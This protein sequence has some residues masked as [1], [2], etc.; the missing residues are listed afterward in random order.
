MFF[1]LIEFII[2]MFV[3]FLLILFASAVIAIHFN[4]FLSVDTFD[5]NIK[6][7]NSVQRLKHIPNFNLKDESEIIL[8]ETYN[9]FKE[10]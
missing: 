5:F 7:G 8:K 3:T 1:I 6:V 9:P 10:R 4:K 2:I